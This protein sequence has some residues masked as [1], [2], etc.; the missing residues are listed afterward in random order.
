V[1]KT[2]GLSNYITKESHS[3][4]AMDNVMLSTTRPHK[5]EEYMW[6]RAA[7]TLCS[8]S[9]GACFVFLTGRILRLGTTSAYL[10]QTADCRLQRNRVCRC[11]CYAWLAPSPKG[12]RIRTILGERTPHVRVV[13]AIRRCWLMLVLAGVR[14]QFLSGYTLKS[15]PR[16]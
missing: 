2:S 12:S 3:C 4:Y 13:D 16:P 1:N 5:G 7:M 15:H 10:V 14:P 6:A 9:A 8:P 11:A